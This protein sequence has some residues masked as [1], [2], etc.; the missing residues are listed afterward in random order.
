MKPM[1]TAIKR[2]VKDFILEK[3]R[4]LEKIRQI[5]MSG[6]IPASVFYGGI[7]ASQS[8]V[9]HTSGRQM[10]PQPVVYCAAKKVWH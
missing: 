3:F 1:A 9:R 7:V 10:V 8:L 5:G 6:M 4:F 2:C